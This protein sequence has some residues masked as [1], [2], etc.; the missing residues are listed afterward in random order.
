MTAEDL[1]KELKTEKLNY[2]C[3]LYGEETYLLE[4]ALK[5]IKK[6]FGE[7]VIRNKLYRT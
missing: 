5:K 3:V 4:T 2:I 1:E 6:L 7:K